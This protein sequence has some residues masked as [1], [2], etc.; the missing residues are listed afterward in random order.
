MEERKKLIEERNKFINLIKSI[1]F[2][3]QKEIREVNDDLS[4]IY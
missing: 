4:E 3:N 1:K 2:I